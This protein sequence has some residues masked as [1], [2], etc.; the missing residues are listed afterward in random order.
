MNINLQPTLENNL[1]RIRPL[2]DEDY[3]QLYQVA[4][5]PLIWEQHPVPD[6]YKRDK[7][8]VFFKD[9]INSK[10]ALVF[11]D[12]KNS[13]IIGSSRFK[14]LDLVDNA[15]EI[16]WTFLSREYWGGKYNGLVKSLMIDHAFN[17][18]ENVI[19]YVTNSNIRSQKA[20]EKIGGKI[21]NEDKYQSSTL[22]ND[23]TYVINKTDW[24]S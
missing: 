7:F 18:F 16:G 22:N 13:K 21:I 20:V 12:K 9:S 23:L 19:L 10:G 2:K 15:V 17:L 1:I 24:N 14:K 6:R 5:D 11:T 4:K 3:E 8:D